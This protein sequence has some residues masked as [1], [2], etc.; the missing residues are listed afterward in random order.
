M[1]VELSPGD[2]VPTAA[3]R[4]SEIAEFPVAADG[5][6]PASGAGEPRRRM[7]IDCMSEPQ[8]NR[9]RRGFRQ[10]YDSSLADQRLIISFRAASARASARCG[11]R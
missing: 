10:L 1:P 7:N 11:G 6:S 9:L 5:Y 2:P 4:V 3:V 8:L